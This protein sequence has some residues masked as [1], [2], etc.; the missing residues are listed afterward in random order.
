MIQ[1]QIQIGINVEF[2]T[3][4]S[5]FNGQKIVPNINHNL[6]EGCLDYLDSDDASLGIVRVLEWLKL[7][8]D[9][10]CQCAV[11]GLLRYSY[12]QTLFS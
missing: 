10:E 5:M 1:L 6:R 12:K 2:M 8:Y 3:S 4:P 9:D 7:W 11:S